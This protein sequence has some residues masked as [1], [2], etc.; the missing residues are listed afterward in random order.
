MNRTISRVPQID[1]GYKKGPDSLTTSLSIIVDSLTELGEPQL[2]KNF[3]WRFISMGS[4][5]SFIS[6]LCSRLE[7]LRVSSSVAIV[8]TSTFETQLKDCP[9]RWTW[10]TLIVKYLNLKVHLLME[11]CSKSGFVT[12]RVELVL[13]FHSQTQWPKT[14]NKS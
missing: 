8:V 1:Q 10:K 7:K 6:C 13:N 2:L 4:G 9:S 14:P 11:L 3:N 5:T 12:I